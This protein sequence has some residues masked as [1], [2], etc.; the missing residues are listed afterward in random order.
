MVRQ[1][2]LM[3]D[4]V[5]KMVDSFNRVYDKAKENKINLRTAAYA[6]ALE[7]I[8]EAIESKGGEDSMY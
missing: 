1:L 4:S 6:V 5:W 2:G 8:K 7:R 3:L